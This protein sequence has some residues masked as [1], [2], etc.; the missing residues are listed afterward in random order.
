MTERSYQDAVQVLKDH[1]GSRWEGLE[2]EGR[3]EMVSILK[4]QLGYD[5]RTANDAIDE[6]I[7]SGTLHYHREVERTGEAVP[8]VAPVAG[9]VAG[10][11]PSGSGG[12]GGVP[13]AGVVARPGHWQIGAGEGGESDAPGRKGQVSPR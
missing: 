1:L 9:G 8:P 4:N 12:L 11:V 6:M 2:T 3:D 10:G 13:L 5:S 7:Q